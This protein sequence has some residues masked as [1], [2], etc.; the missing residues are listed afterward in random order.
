VAR[1]GQVGGAW[2]CGRGLVAAGGVWEGLKVQ[3][4]AGGRGLRDM[5]G[6]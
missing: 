5:G 3:T 4:Q 1:C 2:V 6:A